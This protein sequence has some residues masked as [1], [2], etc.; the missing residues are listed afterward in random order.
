MDE[1]DHQDN[2]SVEHVI[3]AFYCIRR[4]L[5]ETLNGFDEQ[6]FVY[7]EDLDL[8]YRA[9]QLGWQSYYLATAKTFHKGG[10]TTESIKGQRLAMFLQSR[11]KYVFKHLPFWQA[12]L[13]VIMTLFIESLTR[14]GFALIRG[15]ISEVSNTLE[16]YLILLRR[17]INP[18]HKFTD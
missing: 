9:H 15:R 10:G 16:G 1:W 2:R 14:I 4:E 12:I 17:L 11:I 5:F 8:S 18:K 3:G 7:L 6:F 13:I